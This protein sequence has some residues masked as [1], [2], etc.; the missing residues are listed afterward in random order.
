LCRYTEQQQ[1]QPASYDDMSYAGGAGRN[2][3]AKAAYHNSSDGCQ[4]T[5]N[6]IGSRPTVRQSKLFRTHESGNAMKDLLG[7]GGGHMKWDA[8]RMQGGY[9]GKVYDADAH[10]NALAA[11][12][13]ARRTLY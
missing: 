7:N 13:G 5:G 10:N 8:N 4:N 3:G 12:K 6:H 2:A 1:R 11:Q 9:K